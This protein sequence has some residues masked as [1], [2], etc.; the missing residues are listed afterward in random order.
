M[1]RL[2]PVAPRVD[3][4]DSSIQSPPRRLAMAVVVVLLAYDLASAKMAV[5]GVVVGYFYFFFFLSQQQQFDQSHTLSAI[6]ARSAP[7]GGLDIRAGDTVVAGF[8][9]WRGASTTA[10]DEAFT[11]P[12]VTIEPQR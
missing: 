1:A 4:A 12:D 9:V 7:S 3:E 11:Q 6:A 10:P 8:P 2:E 5:V